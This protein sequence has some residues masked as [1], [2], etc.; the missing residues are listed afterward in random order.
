MCS[1]Q[2]WLYTCQLLS[3]VIIKYSQ[4]DCWHFGYALVNRGVTQ[5]NTKLGIISSIRYFKS[6]IGGIL[7]NWG[8]GF[9]FLA[10]LYLT[11]NY[12]Y[13]ILNHGVQPNKWQTNRTPNIEPFQICVGLIGIGKSGDWQLT[14]SV[15]DA[16]LPNLQNIIISKQLYPDHTLSI[17]LEMEFTSDIFLENISL[18][19]LIKT[20]L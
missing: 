20:Y 12:W 13:E 16:Y 5:E 6:P 11:Q 4:I 10:L 8:L 2:S 18:H 19:S 15:D 9:F 3:I 7:P 17:R 1:A 14:D